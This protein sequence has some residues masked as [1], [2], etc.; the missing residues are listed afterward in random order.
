MHLYKIFLLFVLLKEI[1]FS[2]EELSV[3]DLLKKNPAECQMILHFHVQ[4]Y[5]Y[6][7]PPQTKHSCNILRKKNEISLIFLH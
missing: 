5:I 7:L 4:A 1:I 2:S 6:G 3:Y